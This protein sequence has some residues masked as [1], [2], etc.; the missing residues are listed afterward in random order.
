MVFR[1]NVR[2]SRAS[3]CLDMLDSRLTSSSLSNHLKLYTMHCRRIRDLTIQCTASGYPFISYI[4]S[5][6][7]VLVNI[8]PK[9]IAIKIPSYIPMTPNVRAKLRLPQ[10]LFKA[11]TSLSFSESLKN[12]GS[13]LTKFVIT[14]LGMPSF[15]KSENPTS[16]IAYLKSVRSSGLGS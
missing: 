5:A 8:P 10:N 13:A 14:T 12:R 9:H 16:V 15:F 2:D 11:A 6:A 7:P 1:A 4:A 3:L